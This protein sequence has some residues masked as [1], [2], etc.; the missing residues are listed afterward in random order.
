MDR[1]APVRIFVMGDNQLAR[2][3]GLAAQ[4]GAVQGPLPH[5]RR[6][7][8][9]AGRRRQAGLA[10]PRRRRRAIDYTYDPRDPVPT[11]F[12]PG[13]FT[14]ATDQR[15]L[16]NRAD[17]LVYQTEPLTERMEVTGIR[18]SSCM[19]PPP[20]RTPTGWCG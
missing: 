7:G 13:N 10:A 18:R 19:P 4:A 11:L 20:R 6:A 15:R 8:Q 1:D 17:I 3:S 9:H 12:A 2:R 14:C 5:R 16:A